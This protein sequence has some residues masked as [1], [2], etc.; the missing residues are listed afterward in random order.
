VFVRIHIRFLDADLSTFIILFFIEV[1]FSFI[2]GSKHK[3]SVLGTKHHTTRYA[4]C[5]NYWS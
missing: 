4:I 3:P 2:R 5:H 1:L